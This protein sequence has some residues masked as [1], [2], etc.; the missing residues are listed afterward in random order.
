CLDHI[1][2][3]SMVLTRLEDAT[4]HRQGATLLQE[5]LLQ[6]GVNIVGNH[7]DAVAVARRATATVVAV[8]CL[9]GLVLRELL[10]E[11]PLAQAAHADPEYRVLAVH[12]AGATQLA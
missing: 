5:S 10:S 11:A 1:E 3:L 7:E 6:H 12:S 2:L 4:R 9:V 8:H